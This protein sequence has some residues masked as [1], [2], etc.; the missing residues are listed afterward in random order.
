MLLVFSMRKCSSRV[1]GVQDQNADAIIEQML[2][3][4]IHHNETLFNDLNLKFGKGLYQNLF[5]KNVTIVEPIWKE[6]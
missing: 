1:V 5:F 4:F 6:L 2:T 3:K